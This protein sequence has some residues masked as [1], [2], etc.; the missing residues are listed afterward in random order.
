VRRLSLCLWTLVIVAAASEA[1]LRTAFV[2]LVT[3]PLVMEKVVCTYDEELGWRGLA[4]ART[5]HSG[6]EWRVEV[7][8]N[9]RGLRSKEYEYDKRVGAKRV[10]VLGDS[11]AFGYG[12]AQEVAFPS[13]LDSMLGQDVEVINLGTS[14]Y[15]TDQ[16]LLFLRREGVKYHPDLVI[17]AFYL[18]DAYDNLIAYYNEWYGKPRFVVG[19]DG[20]LQLVGVPVPRFEGS[21]YL[22]SFVRRRWYALR[23]LVNVG[24]KFKRLEWFSIFDRSFAEEGRWDVTERLLVEIDRVSRSHGAGMVLVVIPVVEQIYAR[25][26]R[27]P[28]I[29]PEDFDLDAPQQRLVR[30]AQGAGI[31]VVDL[32]PLLREHAEGRWLYFKADN[33]W[34]E[35]GHRLAAEAFVEVVEKLLHE[36]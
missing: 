3:V 19:R 17:V 18:N 30:F 22:V 35:R 8:I 7:K 13:Q 28:G 27:H 6:Q 34:N 25:G 20:A 5:V 23:D 36:G 10:V 32:L 31:E 16:Q 15:S 1:A 29:T 12:V 4:G 26:V 21:S 9:A 11:Y 2:R 14:G 33:H 24:S